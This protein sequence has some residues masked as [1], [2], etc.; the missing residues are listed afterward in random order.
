MYNIGVSHYNHL[1]LSEIYNK[2]RTTFTNITT[3]PD[4]SLL[5]D[6]INR[7]SGLQRPPLP[8]TR[9]DVDTA[10]AEG[11]A[12]VDVDTAY[13]AGTRSDN[14]WNNA[15][16][17]Y[18]IINN[19]SSH[20]DNIVTLNS[21]SIKYKTDLKIT[22]FSLVIEVGDRGRST[23]TWRWAARMR[24]RGTL[25][26]FD[27]VDGLTPVLSRNGNESGFLRMTG[28]DVDHPDFVIFPSI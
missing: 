19:K 14:E 26:N 27:Y 28:F 18:R 25:M 24:C 23:H 1:Y 7:E 9:A 16:N 15:T 12:S 21:Y 13:N 2:P 6:W 22:G 10:R 8:I 4:C 20:L 5:V 17:A 11:V 3:T